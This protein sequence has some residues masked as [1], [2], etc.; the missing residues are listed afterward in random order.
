M[1]GNLDPLLEPLV[2]HFQ[3]ERLKAETAS[4]SS[5]AASRA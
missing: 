3:A 1:D 4:P 5:A 2:A